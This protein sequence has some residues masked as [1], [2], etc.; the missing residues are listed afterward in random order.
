MLVQAGTLQST[1]F[2]LA[3]WKGT[4]ITK[5][6]ISMVWPISYSIASNIRG[7]AYTD[8]QFVRVT[9]IFERQS[10][11]PWSE[12]GCIVLHWITFV[13]FAFGLLLK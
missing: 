9:E 5:R 6:L 3:Q 13:E 8:F 10:Y 1:K 7:T 12:P 4:V 2:E 11:F